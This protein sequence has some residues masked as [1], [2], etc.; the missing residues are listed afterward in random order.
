MTSART[1][2]RRP[3]VRLRPV[4]TVVMALGLVI[5]VGALVV[6]THRAP[7]VAGALTLRHAADLVSERTTLQPGP[8]QYLYSETRSLYQVTIYQNDI[9]SGSSVPGGRCPVF[10]NGEVLVERGRPG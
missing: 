6:G 1:R 7:P 9:S 4:L 8:G 2:S 10:R 3:F 5:A